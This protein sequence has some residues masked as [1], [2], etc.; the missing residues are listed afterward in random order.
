MKLNLKNVTICAADSVTPFLA[1][2]A[3]NKS[4][5]L[6]DFGDAILFTDI[7]QSEGLFR[8]VK[9]DRLTSKQD[10]SRFVLKELAHHIHTEFV[11][12]VQ[13][14]GYVLDA[15]AWQPSFTDFDL[16]GAKWPWHKDGMTVGNGGFTFR[17]KKLLDAMNEP[18]F[19]LISN[20]PED[21]L[22]CRVYRPQ[23]EKEYG[24]R[25]APEVVADA[26]SYE[27]SLPVAPTFGFHGLFNMWRH[28]EDDEMSLIAESFS[29]HLFRTREFFE[30]LAQYV[31]LR[32]FSPLRD[33][34]YLL[35]QNC[36]SNEIFLIMAN[37]YNN[38][39]FSEY[40]FRICENLFASRS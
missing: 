7:T 20:V 40:C 16:I 4:I 5:E 38:K 26:F 24:I 9:I 21:D 18:R 23:L 11:L 10:Y 28:I 27:R 8:N 36:H 2:R 13:W 35:K 37:T 29:S 17:S 15:S 6:C 3:I 25:F 22:I 33:L 14:D 1:A 19:S 12:I 31:L 30:L 39:E 32:K 34:Y